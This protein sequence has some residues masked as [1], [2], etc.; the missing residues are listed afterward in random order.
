MKQIVLAGRY[1]WDLAARFDYA[2]IDPERIHIEADVGRA[3]DWLGANAAGYI[4][5]IT[6]FSDKD[7][8][9]SRVEPEREGQ[10]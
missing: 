3:V 6:C 4:Y 5:A 9:L 10:A 2:G 8:L 1:C 7:K